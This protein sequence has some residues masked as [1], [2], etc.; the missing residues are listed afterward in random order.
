MSEYKGETS[1]IIQSPSEA[2][3]TYLADFTR[4]PEWVKNVSKITQLSSGPIK[5]GTVFKA[6]EGAPP[7]SL[8]KRLRMVFHIL[9]GVLGG[10]KLYSQA[11]ITALEPPRRIAW[12]AGIPKGDGFF[13]VADWEFVLE[14]QGANTRVTQHFHWRP[15]HSQAEHM[16]SVVGV[17]GLKEAVM[18]NLLE[19]KD[20][21]EKKG[22]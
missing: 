4:H 22:G 17:E 9:V 18:V 15:Q 3:Y 12:Q 11:T 16:V 10:A 7:V 6:Q 13:N 19:L 5:V 20:R 14:E 21:L 2:V 1:V 8:T